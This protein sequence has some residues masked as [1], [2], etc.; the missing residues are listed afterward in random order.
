MSSTAR[1]L[2]N[3]RIGLLR[4][5]NWATPRSETAAYKTLNY[6][7]G[8]SIIQPFT[9]NNQQNYAIGSGTYMETEDRLVNENGIGLSRLPFKSKMSKPL[10]ADHL[11]AVFQ[12]VTE[13]ALT[14]YTKTFM[15]VDN[16]QIDFSADS[17]FIY[18]L[19]GD[20]W[21]NGADA[22][23]GFLLKGALLDKLTLK[24]DNM[25]EGLAHF[26]D[27]EGEWVGNV[28]VLE[29]Y[30]SG[31]WVAKPTDSFY[32]TKTMRFKADLTVGAVSK[33][34]DICWQSFEMS[35]MNNIASECVTD[36]IN[37]YFL[38]TVIDVT[39]RIKYTDATYG[40][41]SAY[42]AG[43]NFA[44]DFYNSDTTAD[45]DGEIAFTLPKGYLLENPK[46][47]NGDYFG[48]ELK[49]RIIKPTAAWS[50]LVTFTDA[51]DGAY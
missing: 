31:T 26:F 39:I 3:Q 27:I 14:P 1:H 37:N 4:Q 18:T 28:C 48:L 33:I 44:L 38:K 12:K 51:I 17:G 45:A 8:G 22:G 42:Q 10:L 47:V 2:T 21:N 7:K 34:S 49:A 13:G 5:T 41:F 16:P 30:L 11:V 36:K 35:I 9:V 15:P 24:V 50:T 19:A 23:D 43:T 46:V 6:D 25:G 40:M 32:N 29:K 20:T